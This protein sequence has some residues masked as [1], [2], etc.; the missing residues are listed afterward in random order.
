MLTVQLPPDRTSLWVQLREVAFGS[1][2]F[3]V[4]DTN[5]SERG[6][7]VIKVKVIRYVSLYKL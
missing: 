2:W 1:Y 6:E 4:E 7:V 3:M 5:I